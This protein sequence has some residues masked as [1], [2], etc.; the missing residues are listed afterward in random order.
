LLGI[1]VGRRNDHNEAW[2]RS[3]PILAVA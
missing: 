3:I 2:L 1:L